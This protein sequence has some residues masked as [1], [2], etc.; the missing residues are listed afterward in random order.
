M[1]KIVNNYREIIRQIEFYKNKFSKTSKEVNL[2]AVSKNFPKQDIQILIDE[3]HTIFGENK[4][5]EATSKW[6][7]L[8]LNSREIKLHLLGPLQTNNIKPALKIFD[9]IETLDR[10][11]LAKKI[12]KY[13]DA[14]KETSKHKFFVQVN[15]GNEDQKS[16]VEV[17]YTKEFVKWCI[18]DLNLNV[19]GLM[20][21]PPIYGKAE[22]YFKELKR[23]CNDSNLEHAS[24]G[25]TGDYGEAIR[26]GATFVR[27]GTGIFGGRD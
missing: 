13:F 9:V 20:C 2:I 10:E 24:M 17:N 14:E 8:K 18:N 26:C 15:I 3:G 7:Q 6:P 22:V 11:K 16:G 25:M 23:L 21:I 1:N 19:N 4:V 12:K 5:Q 27:I